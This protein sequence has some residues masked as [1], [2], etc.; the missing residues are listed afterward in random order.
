MGCHTALRMFVC[1]ALGGQAT[2]FAL[3]VMNPKGANSMIEQ[4][5]EAWRRY[6]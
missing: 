4:Q 1:Q 2:D 5:S 6:A 3:L